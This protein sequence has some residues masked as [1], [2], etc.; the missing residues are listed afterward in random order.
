MARSLLSTFGFAPS[1]AM[2]APPPPILAYYDAH[3]HIHLFDG[4]ALPSVLAAAADAGV[5]RAAVCGTHEGDWQ[6]VADLAATHPSFI[7]PSF[8]VHPWHVGDVKPGWEGRLEALLTTQPTA[9]VGESGLDRAARGD[10]AASSPVQRAAVA[11]HARLAVAYTRPLTL[12]CVRAVGALADVLETEAP[13][14]GFPA[15]VVVHAWRGGRDAAARLLAVGAHLSLNARSVVG[16]APGALAWLPLDRVLLESDADGR[17]H[18][19][20]GGASSSP[21]SQHIAVPADLPAVAAAVATAVGVD[22]AVV[23][24]A[25]TRNA[26]RVFG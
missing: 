22:V 10:A 16:V 18:K 23:V 3:T 8:G 13:P 21:H 5:T 6:S 1:A 17:P 14:S 12:H 19:T 7:A 2:A 25:A 15:A 9:G 4:D 26:R 24:E 11:V 20:V